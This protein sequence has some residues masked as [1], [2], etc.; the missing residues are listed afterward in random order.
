M[1]DLKIALLQTI[2]HWE[3]PVANRSMLEE[4]IWQ[5]TEPVDVIVLPEMFT[6]GFTMHADAY[7]EPMNFHTLKWMQQVASQTAAAICGS[8]IVKE[9]ESYYNR[10][11]WVFPDGS[12]KSYDKRHLFRMAGEHEVY[13][14]GQ[15]QLIV[16]WKGWNICPMVCYDLR[17]PV[18]S[19]NVDNAYDALIC[20][21][22]WPESRVQ[23]WSTLLRARAIENI[24]YA[25]GVNRVGVDGLNVPYNGASACINYKGETLWEKT[26]D[27]AWGICILDAKA[28]IDFRQKFPAWKDADKFNIQ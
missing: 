8:Y 15:E 18:W 9:K 10:L 4:K 7:A 20:V 13:G 24:A 3:N 17:F 16:N 23:A 11:L 19:R 22:N 1:Q 6:T 14:A 2:L 26:N 21:A 27:E 5:L 25:A 28:L 12:Y